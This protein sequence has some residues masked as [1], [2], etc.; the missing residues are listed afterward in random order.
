ML[1]CGPTPSTERS[2]VSTNRQL[3]FSVLKKDFRIDTFRAGG[4]G[5]QN[6]NK[7]DTGVRITHIDS[8]AVGESRTHRT[9][10]ENKKEALRR[11]VKHPKWIVWHNRRVAEELGHLSDIE[12]RVEEMMQPKNLKVET[13]VNGVWI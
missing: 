1:A 10:G 8:G 6:Q 5:G 4:P 9:Q 11:L 2:M 13:L 3:L 12:A 7:R